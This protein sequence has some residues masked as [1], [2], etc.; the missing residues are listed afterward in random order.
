MFSL[1]SV[2]LV[3]VFVLVFVGVGVEEVVD[4]SED[5]EEE[6][7]EWGKSTASIF[8]RVSKRTARASW[9]VSSWLAAP[10]KLL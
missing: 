9:T 7:K 10:Y 4:I 1:V 8:P 5:D 2:V 3:L 6:E